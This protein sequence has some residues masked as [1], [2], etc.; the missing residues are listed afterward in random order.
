MSTGMRVK[1]RPS[2]EP[3][4]LESVVMEAFLTSP[5][6][7]RVTLACFL[8]GCTGFRGKSAATGDKAYLVV[9]ED[10]LGHMES[11]GKLHTDRDGWHRLTP[12]PSHD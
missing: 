5:A 2:V 3:H 9:A 6:H 1:I 7:D 10:V 4:P 12:R 8:S 11:Q